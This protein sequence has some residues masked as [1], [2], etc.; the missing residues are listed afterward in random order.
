MLL[1]RNFNTVISPNVN[2]YVIDVVWT[3]LHTS[4]YNYKPYDDTTNIFKILMEKGKEI[5]SKY[6][7]TTISAWYI[8]ERVLFLRELK[9]WFK[10]RSVRLRRKI[11]GLLKSLVFI[12]LLY[13]DTLERYYLPGNNYEKQT[14]FKWS[15]MNN[16]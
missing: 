7:I 15:L 14:A 13:K 1:E 8:K 12:Y 2:E 9:N 10:E 11:K 16:K 6:Q 3:V 4:V 5:I